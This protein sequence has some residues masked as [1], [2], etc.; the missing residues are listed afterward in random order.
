[1]KQK[2]KF[3]DQY[4]EFAD[5]REPLG[6]E[7]MLVYL[8]EYSVIRYLKFYRTVVLISHASKVMLKIFQAGLSTG[9]ENFQT[10]KLG[11][12]ETEIKLQTFIGK[13]KKQE[14]SR[15]TS[16]SASLTIL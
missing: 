11:L 1:M 13:Q 7:G 16:T 3:K 12:E 10:N 15:E 5:H 9:T 4:K 14:S 8:N 6:K 2:Q